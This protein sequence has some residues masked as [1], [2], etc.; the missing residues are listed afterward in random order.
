[1]FFS[2]P[3]HFFDMK[4]TLQKALAKVSK[5]QLIYLLVYKNSNKKSTL[6]TVA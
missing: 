4:R 2:P 1:M 5:L 6:Y 3:P